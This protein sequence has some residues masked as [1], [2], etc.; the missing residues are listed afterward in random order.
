MPTKL[1]TPTIQPR[2]RYA[3]IRR[4]GARSTL[5]IK[6]KA[7]AYNLSRSFNTV[8]RT[9]MVGRKDANARANYCLKEEQS[10]GLKRTARAKMIGKSIWYSLLL[11]IL[12]WFTLPRISLSWRSGQQRCCHCPEPGDVSKRFLFVWRITFPHSDPETG[13]WS[14]KEVLS[15]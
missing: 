10:R 4:L 8:P 14:I 6:K 1:Y 3:A 7:S 12:F 5:T 9:W 15:N 11:M 13:R 2:K